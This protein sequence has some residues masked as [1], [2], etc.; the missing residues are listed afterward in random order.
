ME[1]LLWRRDSIDPPGKPP[2]KRCVRENR[3]CIL[4]GSRR[5]GRRE[6]KPKPEDL[7]G[8][9]VRKP[10]L[11][12]TSSIL[13][14]SWQME[15]SRGSSPDD[16]SHPSVDIERRISNPVVDKTIAAKEIQNPSDALEILAQVAGDVQ[17][18]SSASS[19]H[20]ADNQDPKMSTGMNNGNDNQALRQFPPIAKGLLN[21]ETMNRLLA[22]LVYPRSCHKP[23][24]I[25]VIETVTIRSSP[26][27]H[28]TF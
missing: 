13:G 26:S 10:E 22:V 6:R 3:E 16:I 21:F 5:G 7:T 11:A 18:D 4:A 25:L 15:W 12:E 28:G 2:C 19:V 27:A 20:A 9:E 17:V 14:N 8:T 23:L 1:G 24:T